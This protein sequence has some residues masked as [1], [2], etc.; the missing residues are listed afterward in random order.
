MDQQ[1][2]PK[3][4]QSDKK[5]KESI[6]SYKNRPPSRKFYV[7]LPVLPI[8]PIIEDPELW[9]TTT[10]T[11]K[12]FCCAKSIST[13]PLQADGK[14]RD[15]EPNADRFLIKSY[16]NCVLLAVA[17]GCSWGLRSYEAANSA[18]LAFSTYLSQKLRDIKNLHDAG[19]YILR[20]FSESHNKILE[21]KDDI[22]DAG[23]TTLIGCMLLELPETW[24]ALIANVRTSD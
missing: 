14:T 6:L 21:G 4:P 5:N 8:Q 9:T 16:K 22:W 24:G 12:S 18:V 15:G 2:K 10:D 20:A 1:P 17:D 23:T 3:E 7:E 11:E 13:Y 19:H